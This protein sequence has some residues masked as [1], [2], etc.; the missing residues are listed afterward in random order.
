ME[1]KVVD[2]RVEVR[3]VGGWYFESDGPCRRHFG[4]ERRVAFDLLAAL[5]GH[6]LPNGT[7]VLRPAIGDSAVLCG[8]HARMRALSQRGTRRRV[9]ARGG[10]EYRRAWIG[11]DGDF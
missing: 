11:G 2:A 1:M 10:V 5:T 3:Q 6:A 4:L 9:R 8:C 7:G